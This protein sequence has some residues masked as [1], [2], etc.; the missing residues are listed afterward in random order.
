M[1]ELKIGRHTITT[2]HRDRVVFPDSGITKGEVVEHY[3]RVAPRMLPHMRGRPVSMQRVQ[4]TIEDS[5]FFQKNIGGHFP[6]W[7][8]RVTVPKAGG[9]VTH[10]ICDDAATWFTS[11][12]RAASRRTSGSAA[13]RHS[14]GR[15]G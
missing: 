14:V 7:I 12:T 13:S 9:T 6:D 5:V 8:R 1:T 11:R 4:G 3:L 15:T 2:T 10:V